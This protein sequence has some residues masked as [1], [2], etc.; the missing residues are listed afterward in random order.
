LRNHE[1]C[2]TGDTGPALAAIGWDKKDI[3]S[4][5]VGEA[6]AMAI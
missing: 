5:I 4:K 2:V 3:D 1:Y 6:M